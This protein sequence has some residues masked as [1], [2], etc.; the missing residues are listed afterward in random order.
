MAH[1]EN[2][3]L[4]DA[5]EE[6]YRNYYRDDIGELAQQYPTER[7]SLYLDWDEL[8]RFDPDLADDYQAHPDEFQDYATVSLYPLSVGIITHLLSSILLPIF[9]ILFEMW[10]SR[11]V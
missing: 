3:D 11:L 1:A 9:F 7:K 6:F 2:T 4:I 5:F 8:Y 10:F